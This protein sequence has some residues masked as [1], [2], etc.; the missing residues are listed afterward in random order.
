MS[1]KPDTILELREPQEA[2]DGGPF[3]YNRVRVIG[4]SPMSYGPQPGSWGESGGQGVIIEP[5]TEF[6]ATLDE[7]LGKL[8]KL[9]KVVEEPPPVVIRRG[10]EIEVPDVGPSPEEVFAE[11]AANEPKPKPRRRREVSDKS[12]EEEFA[13][14]E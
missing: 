1:Y 11:A 3:P 7:P 9:Y 4:N 2:K 10:V 14:S 6:A 13:S 12:P 8:Q 5:L